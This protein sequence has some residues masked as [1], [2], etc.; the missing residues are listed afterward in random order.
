MFFTRISPDFVQKKVQPIQESDLE[1]TQRLNQKL[2]FLQISRE[3]LS[4]LRKLTGIVDVHAEAITLRHY[5]MIQEFADLTV[6]IQ[7]HSTVDRLSRTFIAYLQSIPRVEINLDYIQSRR[8]I[9][10]VH[11]RIQLSPEWFAGSFIRIYEYLFPAIIAQFAKKPAELSDVLLALVRILT[12]DSQIALA[13]Y[14]EAHDFEVVENASNIMD[15][16]IGTEKVNTLFETV[17][18]A[19][20]TKKEVQEVSNAT[21]TLAATVQ[22]IAGSAGD[23]SKNTSRIMN[24]I[25]H[26]Q[27]V[28]EESLNGVQTL[29]SRFEETK[30]TLQHLL[31][32]VDDISSVVG[33]IRDIAAQTNLLALNASIEAARAGEHGRGFAVVADEVRKLAEQTTESVFRVNETIDRMQKEAA[34]VEQGTDTVMRQLSVQVKQSTQAIKALDNII[35][36]IDKTGQSIEMIAHITGEQ[37][38]ATGNITKRIGEVVE[39]MQQ[40]SE[41]SVDTGRAVFDI[42]LEFNELREQAVRSIPFLRN[43]EMIRVVQTEHMLW[44]WWLYNYLLGY[45][46]MDVSDLVGAEECR[47]GQWYKAIQ[48]NRQVASLESFKALERPHQKMHELAGEIYGAAASGRMEK[49]RGM[50]VE[51]EQYSTEVV[52]RL[53]QLAADISNTE[54]ELM[55]MER[56]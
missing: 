55:G 12:L 49:A 46:K 24:E 34:E 11:S 38:N 21:C 47:F 51:L 15:I 39:H 48:H 32:E 27:Q 23:I 25:L 56:L 2:K 16:I 14:Q 20:A 41:R 29:A 43:K 13:A 28:I 8:R 30:Q 42:S 35:R 26:G 18:A 17:E 10:Q 3:D 52:Q 33:F 37:K 5:E 4:H 6:I 7:G 19:A 53:R 1:S 22:E 54:V 31:S 44:K 50:L 36:Q 40:I 9:G 45:H